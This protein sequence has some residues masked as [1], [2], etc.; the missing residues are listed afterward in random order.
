[1]ELSVGGVHMENARAQRFALSMALE[2]FLDRVDTVFQRQQRRDL[3]SAQKQGAIMF[4]RVFHSSSF[5]Y[6][7]L[8]ATSN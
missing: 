6:V 2:G 5:P 1:M 4:L 8:P 3:M 7:F